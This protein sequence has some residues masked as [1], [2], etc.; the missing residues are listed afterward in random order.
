ML[1]LVSVAIGAVSSHDPI[2]LDKQSYLIEDTAVLSININPSQYDIYELSIT[3]SS[4]KYTF[5]GTFNPE[6][7]FYPTEEGIYTAALV[8]R[9]TGAI[10]YS[11]SF[12][13]SIDESKARRR[14]IEN[15]IARG[16]D[17][18]INATNLSSPESKNQSHGQNQALPI[19]P[20]ISQDQ[21]YIS[22]EKDRFFLEE[23]I[24][25]I[26]KSDVV[27]RQDSYHL[28]YSSN[29][30]TK[31][32]MGDLSFIEFTPSGIGT[33]EL[34]LTDSDDKLLYSKS[35]SVT[36]TEDDEDFT[37]PDTN[38]I[39][40][41]AHG[42]ARQESK[43]IIH[44]EFGREI[45]LSSIPNKKLSASSGLTN[46]FRAEVMPN[47]GLKSI[48]FN[49]LAL[50]NSS[51]FDLG[52]EEIPPENI[53]VKDRRAIKSFAIDASKLNFISGA[54]VGR[55]VGTELWKCKNWSF[56]SQ[57]CDGTW[58]KVMDLVPGREYQIAITP[59]DPGYTETGVAA[60]NSLKPIYHPG[61]V[62][63][64]W[65]VVL[66]TKGHL[67]TGADISLNVTT[68]LN[69]TMMLTT[70]SGEINEI[71]KGVYGANFSDTY[72]EGNYTLLM[73]AKSS[74]VDSSLYSN[75]EV[76]EEYDFDIIRNAPITTD[77][78]TGPFESSLT[79]RPEDVN[80]EIENYN[81]TEILPLDFDIVSAP[82]A[83]ISHDETKR[84][85]FW[86][87][88]SGESVVSYIAQPPKIT[89]NLF[90]LGRSFIDYVSDGIIRRFIEARFWFLAIDPLQNLF[91]DDFESW[92]C[93]TTGVP[94]AGNNCS[95]SA[96]WGE[97]TN[98]YT[99][100]AARFCTTDDGQEGN[101]A[102]YAI[103]MTNWRMDA[104]AGLWFSL[105]PSIY[106]DIN[107]NGYIYAGSLDNNAEYCMIWARDSNS[108]AA[109]Y[110]CTNGAACDGTTQT[111]NISNYVKYDVNLSGLSGIDLSESNIS[112]H[113]GG[114]HSN[115]ADY[116]FF[117]RINITAIAYPPDV[118]NLT[119]P[120][121]GTTVNLTT[122]DLNFTVNASRDLV[123]P[124]CT[125]WTD[126]N[127]SWAANITIYNVSRNNITNI[128]V[129]P[130]IDGAYNW[131]IICYTRTGLYDWYDNNFTFLVNARP[132]IKNVS[133]VDGDVSAPWNTTNR[134]PVINLSLNKN[135]NCRFSFSSESYEDMSDDYD[136][137]GDGTASISC[138]YTGAQLDIATYSLYFACND[139]Y[140]HADNVSTNLRVDI[141]VLCDSH[142]DCLS[143]EY[144][145]YTQN[146]HSD[147]LP[148][149]PC[150]TQ[151]HTGLAW[152][153]V[154]GNG[155]DRYC[156]N[157][158]TYSYTGWY[159]TGSATDCVYNDQGKS[160][161]LTYNLCIGGTN[162]YKTCD[163]GNQWDATVD[164]ADQYDPFNQSAT[165]H[166][167]EYCAYYPDQQSC[168][169]G[170]AGGCSGIWTGCDYHIYNQ[171]IQTCGSSMEDCDLGCGAGCDSTNSTEPTII[172]GTCYYDRSCNGIC[173]WS[174][175][176]EEAPLSCI[177]DDDGGACVYSN[178]TD[179][180]I[181]GICYWN[182]TCENTL[183]ATQNNN[184]I[185]RA[186]YC[187]FCILSGNNSGEYSPAPNTSCSSGC[188][189]S[190]T[191]YYDTG[192]T[193][194]NRSDDCSN[195]MTI[196]LSDTLATGD[197]WNGSAPAVCDDTECT[198]D[199]G[200]LFGACNITTG[201]C[202]CT[203]MD[204]P[205][206]III[207]PEDG[208]W[209]NNAS[210]RFRYN[211]T[212]I[213]SGIK[214]CS[215]I[216]DGDIDQTNSTIDE[217]L[218]EQEFMQSF[219]NGT[220]LWSISCF[221][222]STQ[223]NNNRSDNG[224]L[225]IDTVAPPVL[226]PSINGSDFNINQKICLNITAN[227]TYAG[228]KDII[229]EI[230]PPG[231][232]AENISLY[233]D[234][235]TSCDGVNGDG[236]FSASYTLIFAGVYDWIT[237][238]AIDY[239]DNQNITDPG[240]DWNVSA[241]GI[242]NL[243][244]PLPSGDI[245]I[246]ESESNNYFLQECNVT[247]S[248][249]GN[250]CDDVILSAEFNDG[251][252]FL[253][254]NT[255][256]TGLVN[257]QDDYACGN[258]AIGQSCAA[259]FNI[260]SGADSGN[261]TWP[262]R[263][264]ADGSTSA[265]TFSGARN[266]TINNHPDVNISHPQ[267]SDWLSGAM[268]INSS[269]SFDSDGTIS[270]YLFEYD[271]KADFDSPSTICDDASSSCTWNT[272]TQDQC[273]NNSMDC[274]LRVTVTDNDGLSNSTYITIGFD[275]EGPVTSITNPGNFAAT[276]SDLMT[277]EATAT[278]DQ[279]GIVNQLSFEYRRN[280][281]DSWKP[282]C[283]DTTEPFSCNWNLVALVDDSTYEVRA[284]AE[285]YFN[286]TGNIDAITNITIDRSSPLTSLESP[287]Q[288]FATTEHNITFYYNV[289]D[290][291]SGILNCELIIDGNVDQT[292]S[293]V[294]EGISQSFAATL[295][296][297]SHLWSVNCT[298]LLDN[299]NASEARNITID[300]S[301]PTVV[302][303]R[304]PENENIS[305]SASYVVNATVTDEGAGNIS[306]VTFEYRKGS[307]GNWTFA[308]NDDRPPLFD[309]SWNLVG[310]EDGDDYEVMVWAN[311]TLGNNGTNDTHTGIKI[312]NN[313]PNITVI[314]PG[315]NTV[316]GDGDLTFSYIVNDSGSVVW[317]CS[318]IWNNTINQ[319]NS[320]IIENQEMSFSLL[321]ISDGRYNW[322]IN[323]TDQFNHK[324]TIGRMNLSVNR[325]NRIFINVSTDKTLY[326]KGN[327]AVEN[328]TI[329]TT[330]R[331]IFNGS[332]NDVN[333]TNDLIKVYNRSEPAG[334]WWN[335]SWAQRKPIFISSNSAV[336]QT[337]ITVTINVTGLN[338]NITN[339]TKEIRV[340]N[341]YGALSEVNVISG[342]NS[343]S[344]Y[345]GF[346]ANVSA[347]AVNQSNYYVYYNNSNAVN[348]GYNNFVNFSYTL[349]FENFDGAGWTQ[350]ATV[351][352]STT[353]AGGYGSFTSC[354]AYATDNDFA[355]TSSGTEIS[356]LYKFVMDQSYPWVANRGVWFN[357]SPT[358]ACGGNSCDDIRV[359]GYAAT[360]SVDTASEF[361]RVWA[362]NT[363]TTA[364]ATIYECVGPTPICEFARTDIA[365]AV[366]ANYTFFNKTLKS[367][368][369][370][371]IGNY[372]AVH[373]GGNGTAAD[374]N[375][376]YEDIRVTG[377]R[378]QAL[379]I[380]AARIGDPQ[381]WIVRNTNR[382]DSNGLWSF[383]LDIAGIGI[384]NY[385]AASL[386]QKTG[387][388]DA[389]NF[390]YFEVTL[391]NI[392]PNIT[393]TS[394]DNDT[395]TKEQMVP[396]NYMVNDSLSGISNC[397]L[398]I[399]GKINDTDSSVQESI[400]KYFGPKNISEGWHNWSV[401]CTDDYNNTGAS[402][403]RT[404]LVDITPPNITMG[405]PTNGTWVIAPYQG[406]TYLVNASAQDNYGMGFV[407][408]MYRVNSSDS[409][410][411]ICNDTGAPY[412]CIW[413]LSGLNNGAYYEVLAYA[414]DS[415]GNIGINSTHFNITVRTKVINVT[416]LIADDSTA[417][418]ID[419]IDLIAG[420]VRSAFCNLT[421]IS[422]DDYTSI[423]S[424]NA[425]L[426][427]ATTT[428]GAVDSNRTHYT[429]SSCSL[430][431]G[432]GD[433]ADYFCSFDLFYYAI[434][435]SWSCTAFARDNYTASNRSDQT[436]VNQLFAIN[437]TSDIINYSSLQPNQVSSEVTIDMVNI[438][439]MP[440]NISVFGFGG[441]NYSIGKNLS[442]I[443]SINNISISSERYSTSS[444]S[445]DSKSNLSSTPRDIGLTIL[446]TNDTLGPNVNTTY[447]QFMVPVSSHSLG[448]CNGSVVFM[449]QSP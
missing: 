447:W 324:S 204:N 190:G 185:L 167:G 375:C 61:E 57:Q 277:L 407:Q 112:V 355:A 115:T 24:R 183:G 414:N 54:A 337:N 217:S 229:A 227:D 80:S 303:D 292:N 203:D 253:A 41:R 123:L 215:L 449:A 231:Q 74:M 108:I 317:N 62:A 370:L 440:M 82:N 59:D 344:C 96:N 323:C 400:P 426:Y 431:S 402:E 28:F 368:L 433:S 220:I 283:N 241:G 310:L 195:G 127:G 444:I 58:V 31:R 198:D 45:N 262:V 129:N 199:C 134:N 284:F 23:K 146:C 394:P 234:A 105:D 205:I 126:L 137:S 4:G 382:T 330:S 138:T 328:A 35:F 47:H 340:A 369:G 341:A 76:K 99:L 208:M 156:V 415:V 141:D 139:T 409:W 240:F 305:D 50:G 434:N 44:D 60:V 207:W 280:N 100:P 38:R 122:F 43:I 145:D 71:M 354:L 263:C 343:D 441:E 14:V 211:I 373:I 18:V 163:A 403:R 85:L 63:V 345:I 359:T 321:N 325:Q 342:D 97:F 276:A 202:E 387:Y 165:T 371:G 385:S 352:P 314:S 89:P 448:L 327:Q 362:R 95:Y 412:Q 429:N 56:E 332:V 268:N 312:D 408:F 430:V 297:G 104:S 249:Q 113:I 293:S 10:Y 3:D 222:D 393:L 266:I 143:N 125:L 363:T 66:D 15:G 335:T 372:I 130:I 168:S 46:R 398:I 351:S 11:K 367:D 295:V 435:G 336:N 160:Y 49:G 329:N 356:G 188:E 396:F 5:R 149:Y 78:F 439:N 223:Y 32:Y 413:N 70:A 365:P 380:T 64:L 246:N 272:T 103:Q 180:S 144:C 101:H 353:C 114:A 333:I 69:N 260:T 432:G 93:R 162:D 248:D 192:S 416:Y 12:N 136:C 51:D 256:S 39:L 405:R 233:D 347:N 102:T 181:Q 418:P 87:N 406:F 290:A 338:G 218:N 225:G 25:V 267:N 153:D 236:V 302:L 210:V 65:M 151:A 187:D 184:S 110:N 116:C 386:G 171:A 288:G 446:P 377:I 90:M 174:Q 206:L 189:N 255:S 68:P 37:N 226:F 81:F 274:Y 132:P 83:L 235:M 306:M 48:I 67:V 443:C 383:I 428:L 109:I 381:E 281:T 55:A 209:T 271:D 287:Q 72:S 360:G 221:D 124:N 307:S 346:K 140:G 133:S 374:D 348:P 301:G 278:D 135:G 170:T 265:T 212:D 224:I 118:T 252:S 243:T 131:S 29:G 75:F 339:C 417:I 445:Y 270:N 159:C 326:H 251:S 120:A 182:T 6:M 128:S 311:D 437:M 150:N 161:A 166:S 73:S 200:T 119:Y 193:P 19:L 313:P 53:R 121:N 397:S 86:S 219:A 269:L 304:P 273:Q 349:F 395:K 158:S 175:S 13:V 420:S 316:D 186:D 419:Q 230:K 308:C 379:N 155:A 84:F 196:I 216:V 8:E 291:L 298:D 376:F 173:A 26:L 389:Y 242:L 106:D 169:N 438:G 391:D 36:A 384:G 275:T 279:I 237:A 254:I 16:A 22:L 191:I 331:D 296:E 178:R 238:Y 289:S 285:D 164:C 245:K 20:A 52:F 410:K 2:T 259:T 77:P 172:S 294:Q 92:G 378:Y 111:P 261:N 442:M 232:P 322:S 34:L 286:N 214:N 213:S 194:L 436:T 411:D 320:S 309:C 366:A 94:A 142:S 177:N 154:C 315:N 152:N 388:G 350:I 250:A 364:Y 318:L 201:N 282:A 300:N 9:S 117:D 423:E 7:F 239:A 107:V 197:I 33:H 88:L 79:I 258:L 247:C 244:M 21:A 425:T 98:C 361:C 176:Q 399:D 358:T 421:I 299:R 264:R 401:N 404:I 157:D 27:S 40:I 228:I 42:G 392:G 1:Q 91:F 424:V 357:T 30:E 319:T 427:S 334:P 148:G 179:P 257:D 422:G 390:T 17:S 147:E